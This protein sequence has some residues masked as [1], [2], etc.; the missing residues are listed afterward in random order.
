MRK[1]IEGVILGTLCVAGIFLG[2]GCASSGASSYIHTGID[3]SYIQ[4]CAVLPFQNLATDNFADERIESIF[5]MEVLDEGA[6]ELVN[7]GETRAALQ[8]LRL[9][10][11]QMPTQSDLVRLGKRLGVDAIFFGTVEQYGINKMS[12]NR[13]FEVTA[14]FSLI[15][16]ET[17]VVIWRS[18]VHEGKISVWRRL[19]GGESASLHEV[20]REVVRKALRTLF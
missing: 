4:R 19:F 10:P 2:S 18:Q 11:G 14:A 5:V 12:K 16:T 20:S 7:G 1:T 9:P 6:L 3:F 15:E 13:V 8:E 17:G